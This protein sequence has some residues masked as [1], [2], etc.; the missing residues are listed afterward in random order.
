MK[1]IFST[2][3]AESKTAFCTPE[4]ALESCQRSVIARAFSPSRFSLPSLFLV[5]LA[6]LS[7]YAQTAPPINVNGA[8]DDWP[9]ALL[10]SG[11]TT[12]YKLDPNS[13]NDDS[14]TQGSKDITPICPTNGCWSFDPTGNTNNKGDITNTGAALIGTKLYFFGDRVSINGDA[15]IGFWFF[16]QQVAPIPATGKFSFAH[17]VGD[18][19]I[20]SNFTNGGGLSKIRVFEWVGT[21][22]NAKGASQFDSLTVSANANFAMVNGAAQPVPTYHDADSNKDWTY[23]STTYPKG[24]FFEGVIDLTTLRDLQ[25]NPLDACFSSYLLETRNSQSITASLQDL[26]ADNFD[27][28]P[29]TYTPTATPY[30]VGN[31]ALGTVTL[32]N[33]Q[34][35]ISYQLKNGTTSVQAAKP[36]T[37]QALVWTGVAGSTS[38]GTAYTVVGTRT[39]TG[40]S[41]T[42]GPVRVVANPLPTITPGSYGPYCVSAAA[43][44]LG[45]TPAGGTWSGTGVTAIS[46]GGGYRFTPGTAGAGT[47]TLTYSY[48]DGNTCTNSGTAS[49][50]VN[51][52]P[53]ATISGGTFCNAGSTQL[54]VTKLTGSGTLSGAFSSSPAGLVMTAAGLIN[55]GT[56]SPGSY[57]ITYTFSD[58]NTC[59]NTATSTVTVNALPGPPDVSVTN[60]DCSH[61]LGSVRVTSPLGTT[62]EYSNNGGA[63]QDSPIFSFAAGQGYSITVRTKGT[64]CVSA[65]ATC[66][67]DPNYAAARVAGPASEPA[68][69]AAFQSIQ[70]EAYPNPTTRDAT[71]NFSVP[72]SGHVLVQVY[73]VLG[74]PVATLFDGEASAGEQRSV[75]L[76][77][78]TLAAGT[79]TYRVVA[80][81]KTKT[82]RVILDK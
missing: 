11:Y 67:K 62:L 65:A 29:A 30:C 48:T 9:A 45:G 42:S 17:S 82:N 24:A 50:T 76:K 40:C 80:N 66:A 2:V 78:S 73:N 47:H 18:L 51:A 35:N 46:G 79:Y 38:P 28:T 70:T 22:G 41:S 60:P 68:V 23:G 13:S 21:G 64:V 59:S 49:V 37:G 25:G 1:L 63:Y 33:S 43:V 16:K 19:L 55:L 71:I 44:T 57:T 32:P 77:G 15:Q 56:S 74:A 75:V 81:G 39:G 58:S 61:I 12:G 72:K 54:T 31:T 53:T 5:L 26:A 69:G 8:P 4:T 6:T 3:G 14:F 27:V 20:L 34:L 52:L 10:Y 7:S 36:G